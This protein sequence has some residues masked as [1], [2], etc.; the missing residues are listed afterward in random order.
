MIGID[1][2]K[3]YECKKCLKVEPR[4]YAMIERGIRAV[5]CRHCKNPACVAACPVEALEKPEGGDLKRYTMK[6]VSCKQCAT[7]CPVGANPFEVLN[8]RSF[9]AYHVNI[10]KCRKICALDAIQEVTGKE[11]DWIVVDGTFA[12]KAGNWK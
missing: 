3:C 7:A 1:L 11:K 2:D 5:V 4:L 10:D 9:P 6:C 8:Y 12:V